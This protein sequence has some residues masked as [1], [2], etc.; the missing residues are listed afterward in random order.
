MSAVCCAR[1]HLVLALVLVASASGA[2]TPVPPPRTTLPQ[3]HEY[4]KQLRSFMATLVER[5]FE[6]GVTEVLPQVPGSSDPEVQYRNFLFTQLGPPLVG[7]KRGMPAINTPARVFTL[8]EI[9]T[10]AG[11]LKPPLY[12]EAVI[13]LTQWDYEGNLYRDNRGLRLR[14]FVTSAM[15]MMML[16]DYIDHT[17]TA[18]RVDRMGYQLIHS[19]APYEGFK[20]LLSAEAQAGYEAGL[21][22]LARRIMAWGPRGEEIRNDLMIPV[23]LWYCSHACHAPEFAKEVEAW[24]RV[25]YTDPRY[26]HPAGYFV[27]RGGVDVGFQGTANFFAG[28]T[29]LASSW[30][31]AKDAVERAYRLR[32]HLI[33][34]EPGGK[35][36]GPTHFNTRLSSPATI[37]QWEW[38]KMRDYSNSL[39]TDEAAHL[40]PL[41]DAETLA[42][43]GATRASEFNRQIAENPIGGGNG[44]A[45]TPYVYMK[46]NEIRSSPWAWR[47][48]ASYNF[49]TQVNYGHDAYPQGAFARRRKLEQENSP[50]L[51][52][53]FLR[54]GTFVRDFDKAFTVTKQAGYAAIVHSG[55]VGPEKSPEGFSQHPGPLGLGGGQLS[56]F[57][58]PATG[59]IVLGRRAGMTK[60]KTF[61]LLE[62]WRLWPIHAVSGCTPEGRVFTTARIVA[63]EVT[64]QT[65]TNSATVVVRGTIP[66]TQLG[67]EPS[68]TGRIDYQR[69]F[70]LE[71]DG[72]RIATEIK[73][74][75]QDRLAELF[76][77]LPVFLGDPPVPAQPSPTVIELQRDGAWKPATDQWQEQVTAARLTR[78]EG[79]VEVRFESPQRVKLSAADWTDTWFTRAGCRNLVID[80]LNNQDQ[81]AP[82]RAVSVA[83]RILP[84]AR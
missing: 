34:P 63:P 20:S 16:D 60:D 3:D 78:F 41:P 62:Q 59:A 18:Q 28:W 47:A 72:V 49:P 58:T 57:W 44:S 40:V 35:S 7:S 5:D 15:N 26:F 33:L 75:G 64:S 83:Y 37:D 70:Q 8:R 30:P 81:P 67:Q 79:A 52:S 11:V 53:P 19:A 12:P 50:L 23:G 65:G 45:E 80:L 22:R 71:P 46:N 27:D 82:S 61:D 9:E 1:L 73:G 14:A 68:L 43:A 38:G 32:A 29:A 21:K 25:L 39:V 6:H 31:F 42:K 17:P 2:D 13:S 69:T 36:T 66:G 74:G 4:Q 10:P 51:K 84:V 48:W 55:T 77:T 56:A 54:E 76:E 24:A